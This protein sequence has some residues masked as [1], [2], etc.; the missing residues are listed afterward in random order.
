MLF[1]LWKLRAWGI[2]WNAHIPHVYCVVEPLNHHVVILVP[3][4][5][6]T[7]LIPG[8]PI[9]HTQPSYEEQYPL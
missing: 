4:P 1:P 9:L 2:S 7:D 6:F 3:K 8:D 5:L